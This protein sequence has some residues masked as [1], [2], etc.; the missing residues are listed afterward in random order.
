MNVDS[1][2]LKCNKEWLY[3]S[4]LVIIPFFETLNSGISTVVLVP[5]SGQQTSLGGKQFQDLQQ[6]AF[7]VK[8]Q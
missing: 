7:K 3:C 2:I 8:V 5:I 6:D 1:H 4:L